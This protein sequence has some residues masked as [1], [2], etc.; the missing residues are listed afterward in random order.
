MLFE[1]V[2]LS[3]ISNHHIG[4][5]HVMTVRRK[6]KKAAKSLALPRP[7]AV[8]ATFHVWRIFGL[9]LDLDCLWRS[10]L[11]VPSGEAETGGWGRKSS[12]PDWIWQEL[13]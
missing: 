2:F 7:E 3:E 13:R 6:K 9:Y 5:G 8:E 11:N 1:S 10:R 12:L 4:S